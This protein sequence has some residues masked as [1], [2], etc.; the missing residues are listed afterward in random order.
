MDYPILLTD[1]T[2][3]AAPPIKRECAKMIH[4]QCGLGITIRGIRRAF[5]GELQTNARLVALVAAF[6]GIGDVE[7]VIRVAM[8]GHGGDLHMDVVTSE[9]ALARLDL[10]VEI[11]SIRGSNA[12]SRSGLPRPV[13][14]LHEGERRTVT[15]APAIW[16][17]HRGNADSAVNMVTFEQLEDCASHDLWLALCQGRARAEESFE[18]LKRPKP[19]RPV[20]WWRFRRRWF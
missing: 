2:V 16:F 17:R 6:A 7:E 10:R 13:R 19:K 4:E 18:E 8:T 3:A 9:K 14:A 1:M 15:I 5:C 12:M 11:D 20:Q